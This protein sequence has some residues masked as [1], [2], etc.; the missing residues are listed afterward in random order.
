MEPLKLDEFDDF[1]E[2][3]NFDDL[4]NLDRWEEVHNGNIAPMKPTDIKLHQLVT[5]NLTDAL[6]A[7]LTQDQCTIYGS[8]VG[9]ILPNDNNFVP[10]VMA[11]VDHSIITPTGITGAPSFIAEVTSPTSE[12]NDRGHKKDT[13]EANGV[14]EYWILSPDTKTIE[15]YLNQQ[16]KFALVNTYTNTGEIPVSIFDNISLSLSDIF[17]S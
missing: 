2:F 11:I 10:D 15:V 17:G 13:Y 6:T 12:A 3:D 16:G 14:K 4:S 7:K 5:L 1:D 8:G 9:I